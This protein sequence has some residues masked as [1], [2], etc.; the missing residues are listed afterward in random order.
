MLSLL[1]RSNDPA[2]LGKGAIGTG[3]VKG[4]EAGERN[5]IVAQLLARFRV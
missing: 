2:N 3:L 5:A 1:L 4:I